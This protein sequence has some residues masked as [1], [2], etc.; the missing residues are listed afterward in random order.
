MKIS[1]MDRI[2]LTLYTLVIL[3]GSLTLIVSAA[4]IISLGEFGLFLQ[5]NA[6]D[7]QFR[8]ISFAIGLLFLILS[9][10]LMLSGQMRKK[11]PSSLLRNTELGFIRVS[12]QTLDT[13]AQ[14]A[15]REFKEIKDVKT[16]I[17]IEEDGIRVNLKITVMPEVNIPDLTEKVQVQ[18]KKYVES[19]SG[20]AVKAVPI[21]VDNLASPNPSRVE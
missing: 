21:Y 14:K 18:L 11:S 5:N 17:I 13:L 15:V 12:H 8:L 7:W 2:L 4:G 1:L 16:M 6:K 9:L 3:L 20:V 19:W 10:K